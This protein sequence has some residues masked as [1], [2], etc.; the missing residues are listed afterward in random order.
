M[1]ETDEA[2]PVVDTLWAAEEALKSAVGNSR[3]VYA[4]VTTALARSIVQGHAL[5]MQQGD[6]GMYHCS[7]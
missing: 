6:E 4:T 5:S 7:L 2:D 1:Q 3:T